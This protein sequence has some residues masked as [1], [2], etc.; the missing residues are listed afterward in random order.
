MLPAACS[1]PGTGTGTSCHHRGLWGVLVSTVSPLALAQC[2]PGMGHVAHAISIRLLQALFLP[3]TH[4]GFSAVFPAPG[5]AL[6]LASALGKAA[7]PVELVQGCT[8]LPVVSMGGSGSGTHRA[9]SRAE[10]AMV[11]PR[12]VGVRGGCCWHPAQ[13]CCCHVK[14]N[15]RDAA[16]AKVCWSQPRCFWRLD[17]TQSKAWCCRGSVC[18]PLRCSE[19]HKEETSRSPC[20]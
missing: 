20:S 4:P 18:V 16:R 7:I 13:L 8:T 2:F 17:Q 3:S 10:D 19:T 9:E 15:P 12:H 1:K 11:P 14:S 5:G 6:S